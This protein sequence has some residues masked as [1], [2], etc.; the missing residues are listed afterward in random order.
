MPI[1]NR[2][3]ELNPECQAKI[4]PECSFFATEVHHK[5]GK[6]GD[7]YFDDR[8]FLASCPYCHRHIEVNP[9]EAKEKG[10]SLDRDL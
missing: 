3:L 10:F 4:V 8:W 5:K 1:R 2:F 9:T 6:T 7:L